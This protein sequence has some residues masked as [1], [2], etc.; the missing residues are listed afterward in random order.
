MV[1]TTLD[2]RFSADDEE[3][4]VVVG[5][6]ATGE[7]EQQ[8]ELLSFGRY[9]GRVILL[10]G[11]ER[12]APLVEWLA[13]LENGPPD[14]LGVGKRA[15]DRSV[16][17]GA[18]VRVRARFLNARS[19]P[20]MFFSVKSRRGGS[21]HA[22]SSVRLLL[23][24]LLARG[25]PDDASSREP[26]AAT[27]G[28]IGRAAADGRLTPA[29]EFDVALA[30]ADIAWRRGRAGGETDEAG[31]ELTCPV[32]GVTGSTSASS[33]VFELRLWPSRRARLR[34]CMSCGSGL[35]LRTGRR[36]RVLSHE[37][38]ENMEALRSDLTGHPKAPSGDGQPAEESVLD[39][40]AL[41]DELK[42]IFV[43]HRW[44]FSEV[45]GT[46]VLVSDLSGPLGTWRFYAQVVPEQRL[47]LLYSICPLRV[48][49]ARRLE[50]SHFLTHA[51]YGLAAGNFELDFD[52]GEIRYKTP[53]QV[54]GPLDGSTVKNLVRANGIAMETYLPGIGAVITGTPALPALARRTNG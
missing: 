41:L 26:L 53:L 54:D 20:R 50:V 43:A 28:L 31:L 16:G 35:W 44:P 24:E 13:R 1:E 38:W 4:R 52:D 49:E 30:A 51:N 29:T 18:S 10:L 33:E 7:T 9:A 2:I 17:A 42:Q 48:P 27:A 5:S 36:P 39:S 22:A 47:I 15:D 25:G 11:P 40:G 3:A 45:R 23:S 12:A 46:P 32:C 8:A 37:V 34:K 14:D 19:G 21:D 6:N